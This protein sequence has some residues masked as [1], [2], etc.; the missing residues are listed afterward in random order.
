MGDPAQLERA[1]QL[2][3][4][5]NKMVRNA[6]Q[7]VEPIFPEYWNLLTNANESH[8]AISQG[9]KIGQRV[10]EAVKKSPLKSNLGILMTS[11][12][13]DPR[14]AVGY[15]LGRS[16]VEAV[17]ILSQYARSS[18]L[19]TYYNQMLRDAVNNDKTALFGIIKKIDNQAVKEEKKKKIN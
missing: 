15:G 2:F 17:D 12:A 13:Y 11:A 8:S 19:R 6:M 16:L 7:Q 10:E 4:Q 9:I 14:L 5:V 1:R 3:P 18:T